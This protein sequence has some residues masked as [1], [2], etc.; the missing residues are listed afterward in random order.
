ML[1]ASSNFEL[2]RTAEYL[3]AKSTLE[4]RDQPRGKTTF[5]SQQV[6][7]GEGDRRRGDGCT[8]AFSK[9]SQQSLRDCAS[10]SV[11]LLSAVIRANT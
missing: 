3:D 2:S 4:R 5:L 9:R 7:S 8:L 11:A 6:V 1:R 10:R